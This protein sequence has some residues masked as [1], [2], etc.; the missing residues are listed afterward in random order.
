LDSPAALNRLPQHRNLLERAVA[1]FRDDDRVLGLVLG[2]SLALGGADFYSDV[3]LYVI[4]RNESLDA[5]FAERDAAA[6]AIGSPLLRFTVEPVPGGSR[7]YIVTYP[8]PVKLDLMYHRESEVVPGPKWEDRPV[9]KD[10]SGSLAVVVS[11]SAGS[12]PDRHAPEALAELEQK[13]WTW[14][15]YVFGKISRGE[16]W[17]ALDGLHT[18]RTLALLPLLD[19][20]AG[21]PHEG[22]RRLER[23]LDPRTSGLLAATVV[24][25][26]PGALY[27]ALQAEITLFRELRAIVFDRYGLTFDPKP[28]EIIE[29]EISRRW[30]EEG[31]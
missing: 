10:D 3:D 23:K 30:A 9:L 5:V 31:S 11:R 24:P 4:V 28:G 15:W 19:R 18:I 16:L 25:L 14:C 22:Y 29:E 17:E 20:A 12:G 1:R 26:Q 6:E 7:D 27:A 21:R 13:F 8:G 2:G